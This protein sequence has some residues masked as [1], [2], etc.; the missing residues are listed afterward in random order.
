MSVSFQLAFTGE[1]FSFLNFYSLK[2]SSYMSYVRASKVES[3]V[4]F[5]LGTY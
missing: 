1:L 2:S 4:F 3:F 5:F